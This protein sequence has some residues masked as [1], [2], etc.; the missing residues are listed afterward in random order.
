MA[1]SL[2]ASGC[3]SSKQ[4]DMEGLGSLPTFLADSALIS[5]VLKEHLMF[6]LVFFWWGGQL[7]RVG[8]KELGEG[9]SELLELFLNKVSLK[10]CAF[11]PNIRW[12]GDSRTDKPCFSCFIKLPFM[13]LRFRYVKITFIF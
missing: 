1:L 11:V 10:M 2:P 9:S 3:Q 12:S 8:K 7:A 13:K 4:R 6:W 5:V